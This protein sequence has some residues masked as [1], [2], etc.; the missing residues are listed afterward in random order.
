MNREITW[1]GEKS[2]G[3]VANKKNAQPSCVP[4]SR[5]TYIYIRGRRI[6]IGTQFSWL[7]IETSLK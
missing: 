3:P 6:N 2:S 5:F 7:L 4:P 1:S